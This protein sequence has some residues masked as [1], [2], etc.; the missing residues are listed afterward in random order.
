MTTVTLE[1][2]SDICP[3]QYWAKISSRTIG[4][5]RLRY[6][7]L[8]CDFFPEHC[9]F[10]KEVRLVDHNFEGESYKGSFYNDEE[11]TYWLDNCKKL[12]LEEYKKKEAEYK[13]I[14]LRRWRRW[15]QKNS[16]RH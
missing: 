10:Y 2:I 6:G 16:K 3:E 11:R 1:K 13:Q 4:Y 12:L 14:K 8:T 15:R 5:I 7:H 9:L